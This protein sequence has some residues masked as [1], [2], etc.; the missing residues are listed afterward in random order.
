MNIVATS[1]LGMVDQYPRRGLTPLRQTK[2]TVANLPTGRTHPRVVPER[3]HETFPVP[4]LQTGGAELPPNS[5]T[6][7]VVAHSFA[8]DGLLPALVTRRAINTV[9]DL[10][11]AS[12]YHLDVAAGAVPRDVIKLDRDFILRIHGNSPA[13]VDVKVS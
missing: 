2:T 11:R 4:I 8:V 6:M 12:L 3:V 7:L 1:F 10:I 9:V 13:A 5:S